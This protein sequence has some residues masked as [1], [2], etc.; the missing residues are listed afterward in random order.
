MKEFTELP[1]G[2][3]RLCISLYSPGVDF[4][5][6]AR[7]LTL[8]VSNGGILKGPAI[9][10]IFISLFNF[11]FTTSQLYLVESEF[12]TKHDSLGPW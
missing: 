1:R 3:D 2:A 9:L 12:S 7:G 11:V 5:I 6:T 4:G 10:P 8:N